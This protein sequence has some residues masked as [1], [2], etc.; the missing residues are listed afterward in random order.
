MHD[1]KD[2]GRLRPV[3]RRLVIRSDALASDVRGFRDVLVEE[4]EARTY[5]AP[6]G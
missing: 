3:V 6:A 5:L 1:L 2:N 4:L